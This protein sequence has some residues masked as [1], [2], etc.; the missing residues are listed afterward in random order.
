M[1]VDPMIGGLNLTTINT[2]H[3]V[4]CIE[5]YQID[6]NYKKTDT[7]KIL[8]IVKMIKLYRIYVN[9]TLFLFNSKDCL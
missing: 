5:G 9:V 1:N 3:D 8:H 7:K 4:Y 2:L 6:T